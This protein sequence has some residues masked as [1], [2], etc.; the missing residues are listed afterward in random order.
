[1]SYAEDVRRALA[2]GP[3]GKEEIIDAL[4]VRHRKATAA[5]YRDVMRMMAKSGILAKDAEGRYYVAREPTG[6]PDLSAEAEALLRERGPITVREAV[7]ALGPCSYSAAAR[8]LRKAA[9]PAGYDG[10]RIVFALPGETRTRGTRLAG[11]DV[12]G[13]LREHGPC[14]VKEAME[15]LGL[16]YEG[17][18]TALVRSAVRL[19]GKRPY[20]YA[21]KEGEP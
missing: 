19:E 7:E 5:A 13:Y 4:G 10:K 18:R 14:T 6:R 11:A 21:L 20:R 8:A 15:A 17:A 3:R 1:M 16:S 2:A 9:V 12:E